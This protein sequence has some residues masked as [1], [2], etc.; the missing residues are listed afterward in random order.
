MNAT[1]TGSGFITRKQPQINQ[2]YQYELDTIKKNKKPN[3]NNNTSTNIATAPSMKIQQIQTQ[4]THIQ[5]N[6]SGNA[7]LI[8]IITQSHQP[9]N[10]HIYDDESENKLSHQISSY[11]S[12]EVMSSL[13]FGFAASILFATP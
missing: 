10:K 9:G 5:Q 2:S 1:V 6:Q 7:N 3:Q 12:F 4:P 11:S 8:S 13:M